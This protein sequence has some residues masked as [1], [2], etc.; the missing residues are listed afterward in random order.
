MIDIRVFRNIHLI[1]HSTH[2]RVPISHS[3]TECE[4]LGLPSKRNTHK[5]NKVKYESKPFLLQIDCRSAINK[6][7]MQMKANRNEN[8]E[9]C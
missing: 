6:E 4:G 1:T 3:R 9:K 7:L 5:A 2:S 8:K